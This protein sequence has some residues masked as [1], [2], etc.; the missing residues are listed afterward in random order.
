MHVWAA[1]TESNLH[2]IVFLKGV[3]RCKIYFYM[4]FAY[5][6]VCSVW[7]QPPYNIKQSIHSFFVILKKS[8]H[9][10]IMSYTWLWCHIAHAPPTNAD[11]LYFRHLYTLCQSST[12][13]TCPMEE[14]GGVS[15]CSLSFKETCTKT[16]RCE[17]SCFWGGKKC[18]VLHNHW[19]IL[20]KVCYKL[21]MKTLKNHTNLWKN[22]HPMTP[23]KLNF[24][25][26]FSLI[27]F[28]GFTPHRNVAPIQ[29][30]SSVVSLGGTICLTD[31]WQMGNNS[32]K[33]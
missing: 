12:L 27:I 23:L 25:I 13:S 21:Y 10:I 4:V 31:Q 28:Y 8:K 26:L 6:C 16:G 20:T 7:T 5:K 33:Q 29:I 22:W 1:L 3:I 17:Q 14:R 32:W 11:W 15:S 9:S 2:C 18:V 19:G 24:C 30:A